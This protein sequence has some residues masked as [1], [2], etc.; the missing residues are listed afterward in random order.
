M[1]TNRDRT[2]DDARTVLD[3]I[4]G[5]GLR[6]VG[7]KDVG[8]TPEL[9]REL[10]AQAKAAGMTVYLEVVSLTADDE[11]RSI[12]AALGAGVDWVLG[13]QFAETASAHLAG[14][15][16]R[17]APFPGKIVGHPSELTGSVEEI[18]DHAGALSA[19]DGVDGVDLLAYRHTSADV[20]ELIRRTVQAVPG[21]VIVA[22][23]V[24]TE[25]QVAA[26]DE[27]G[28]WGFTIGG[29]IFDGVLPGE[30]DVVS[31][32]RTALAFAERARR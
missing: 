20:P 26:I 31:Q 12:D 2:V 23:S 10:T 24:T 3:Q 8:A 4:A 30:K 28:A 5:T 1:L 21:R 16:I 15:G 18:A 27:A 6:H 32:V 9:Q 25:A 13:G 11:R 22:G 14:S 17:F 19:L 29:A 7:F